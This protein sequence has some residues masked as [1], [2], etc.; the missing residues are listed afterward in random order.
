MSE[1]KEKR[2]NC[3]Y[4][5]ESMD[6]AVE[7]VKSG[8]S[9]MWEAAKKHQIP[10]QTLKD[11]IEGKHDGKVGRKCILSRE[12]EADMAS[13]IKERA[14]MA[15]PLTK[16]DLMDAAFKIAERKGDQKFSE[17]GL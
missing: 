9:T 3:Q 8:V 13:W 4:P 6:Q 10:Y 12:D 11:K 7:D 17:E 15:F 1:N 5:A 2:K 14:K 16:D